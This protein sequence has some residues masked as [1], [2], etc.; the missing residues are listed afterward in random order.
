M[1]EYY[2]GTQKNVDFTTFS[3]A[4]SWRYVGTLEQCYRPSNII[5][6][7]VSHRSTVP[8]QRIDP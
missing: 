6:Y 4:A 2:S 7:W 1:R 8:Y 3:L 5:S